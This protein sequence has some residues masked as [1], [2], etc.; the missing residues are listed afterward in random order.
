MG[1]CL[2][3]PGLLEPDLLE[4][5]LL[6]TLGRSPFNA[7]WS[8]TQYSTCD[9]PANRVCQIRVDSAVKPLAGPASV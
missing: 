6:E 5:D 4:P 1:Q 9:A 2:L 3:K 7:E 8:I